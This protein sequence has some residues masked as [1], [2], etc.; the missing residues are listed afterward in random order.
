MAEEKK[1]P[2]LKP[3]QRHSGQFVKND[4]R[5]ARHGNR[6]HADIVDFRKKIMA[7]SDAALEALDY[8]LDL[9]N[10][11]ISAKDRRETA[12]LVLNHAHGRPVDRIAIATLDGNIDGPTANLD[13]PTLRQRAASLISRID[14][15]KDVTQVVDEQ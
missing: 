2:G 9:N 3:G 14:D 12:E 8:L 6:K 15:A 4:P 5:S 10:K 13:L 1:R 7:R 11:D